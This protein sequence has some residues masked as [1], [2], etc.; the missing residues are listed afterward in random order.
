[1][2]NIKKI[3]EEQEAEFYKELVNG[4][5]PINSSAN[6][7][8]EA[9][10]WIEKSPEDVLDFLRQSKKTLAQ[11]IIKELVGE[12]EDTSKVSPIH[13]PGWELRV[14]EAKA[15]GEEILKILN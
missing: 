6:D 12:E 14:Q 9:D 1:M 13:K 3:L 2:N 5:P 15:K 11:A 8:Q 4:H 7:I 10:S